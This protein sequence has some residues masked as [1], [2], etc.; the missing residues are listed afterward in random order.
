MGA[1]K[2]QWRGRAGESRED[3]CVG[4]LY[5]RSRRSQLGVHGGK[6]GEGGGYDSIGFLKEFVFSVG[7][8]ERRGIEAGIMMGLENRIEGRR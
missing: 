1:E 8:F 6:G 5:E 3:R 7:A 4:S 2:V